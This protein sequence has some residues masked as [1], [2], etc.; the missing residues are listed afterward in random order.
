M[1]H[2]CQHRSSH[3]A[4][5]S[6]AFSI[7]LSLSGQAEAAVINARSASFADVRAAVAS[8]ADGD[9]VV[10][11]AGT[12]TWTQSMSISKAITLKGAG[13]G[14]TVIQEDLPSDTV[15]LV[16]E[17]ALGKF[18]RLT[19][20]EFRAGSRTILFGKGCVL[21]RGSSKTFRID[22]C[23]WDH[24]NNRFMVFGGSVCGVVDHNVCIS[25]RHVAHIL[26]RHDSWDGRKFGDGSWA[27]PIDWGG[28]NAVYFEDN[29][30]GNSGS[31]VTAMSDQYSGARLVFRHNTLSNVN[32]A[33]HGTGSSG[34]Q[35][36][37]RQWEIY[38]NTFTASPATTKNAIH[39]RGGTGVVFDNIF[40]GFDKPLTLHTYRY[41]TAFR[42]W[43]GS[44]GTSGWDLNDP[45]IYASG[46]AGSG[47]GIGP[48][49]AGGTL[50]VP[51]AKWSTNQWVGYVVRNL[52]GLSNTQPPTSEGRGGGPG[53]FF[54]DIVSNTSDTI[55][56]KAGSQRPN[57]IFA[58]GDRFEI[59]K[60]I[61]GLD[62]IG[63]S[64]GGLLSGDAPTPRWLNQAIEPVYVWNNTK[65]G[66]ANAGLAIAPD[67]PI[68]EGVHFLNNKAKPDYKPL[69]YPHPLVTID[70]T[71]PPPR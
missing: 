25:R 43:S 14:Q 41:H 40:T 48:N 24:V 26:V 49:G 60:V 61:Q 36:G 31:G 23:K 1:K 66:V 34:R 16:F 21:F 15:M 62:M 11:P 30:F 22:H 39:M 63:G 71:T 13:V 4:L 58:A 5:L 51:G 6:L 9:T 44:D 8:A 2:R 67:R 3:A 33:S 18:Y 54:S 64:T 59:R 45:K 20:I 68:K 35:R 27:T 57:K 56:A 47:S 50:V 46:T 53:P 38:S 52:D 65:D 17:T 7:L 28:T 12:N 10:I 32:F 70:T 29:N 37:V 69:V 55:I 42:T 19:G